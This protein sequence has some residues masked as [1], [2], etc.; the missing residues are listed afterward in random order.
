M[1]Q[2]KIGN[3]R[4][5]DVTFSAQLKDGNKIEVNQQHED[6]ATFKRRGDGLADF[7]TLKQSFQKMNSELEGADRRI[8][9]LEDYFHKQSILANSTELVTNQS[10]QNYLD[11]LTAHINAQFQLKLDEQNVQ[12]NKILTSFKSEIQG[13]LKEKANKAQVQRDQAYV[14]E[15]AVLIETKLDQILTG[16]YYESI[17]DKRLETKADQTDLESVQKNKADS[18]EVK[19]CVD[20]I[21]RLEILI[22]EGLYVDEEDE[23]EQ[24]IYGE[25]D[26]VDPEELKDQ[27]NNSD[28]N[29]SMMSITNIKPPPE[30]VKKIIRNTR[31]DNVLRGSSEFSRDDNQ[32]AAITVEENQDAP[33]SKSTDVGAK[34]QRENN[35]SVA[36]NQLQ[37]Q[38]GKKHQKNQNN[39]SSQGKI[40]IQNHGFLPAEEIKLET[41]LHAQSL[42]SPK[43]HSG[44]GSTHGNPDF[45]QLNTRNNTAVTPRDH[46]TR[47]KNS[48]KDSQKQIP[49]HIIE[50]IN[51]DPSPRHQAT[52]VSISI[53]GEQTITE[54]PHNMPSIG[55]KI[56]VGGKRKQ[57][58]T[59][60]NYD[61]QDL[62]VSHG[63]T[64]LRD[65]TPLNNLIND[66]M[67]NNSSM[68]RTSK[69]SSPRRRALQGIKRGQSSDQ[70]EKNLELENL[71]KELVIIN[72]RLKENSE[73]VMI[74]KSDINQNINKQIKILQTDIKLPQTFVNENHIKILK[75]LRQYDTMAQKI[76]EQETYDEKL[77]RKYLKQTINL[78]KDANHLKSVQEQE[79]E[80]TRVKLKTLETEFVVIKQN[81]E[82]VKKVLSST[83]QQT[84]AIGATN[85]S[86]QINVQ[87]PSI[88]ITQ[89]QNSYP[90]INLGGSTNRSQ[91]NYTPQLQTQSISTN[92][93]LVAMNT[94]QT[95]FEYFKSF[96][97]Q[98]IQGVYQKIEEEKQPLLDEVQNLKRENES[99]LREL[100]RFDALYRNM[101]NDYINILEENKS[102]IQKQSELEKQLATNKNYIKNATFQYF[103]QG[104]QMIHNTKLCSLLEGGLY[105]P[106][107][108]GYGDDTLGMQK[109]DSV[110]AKLV[111]TKRKLKQTFEQDMIEQLGATELNSKRKLGSPMHNL[112]QSISR[113][114]SNDFRARTSAI[115]EASSKQINKIDFSEL[116]ENQIKKNDPRTGHQSMRKRNT[117]NSS[118]LNNTLESHSTQNTRLKSIELYKRMIHNQ[119]NQTL[120]PSTALDVVS[121]I[122]NQNVLNDSFQQQSI[123]KTPM[124][125]T[126]PN[127]PLRAKFG[128]KDPFAQIRKNQASPQ[129]IG[130]KDNH[131]MQLKRFNYIQQQ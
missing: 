104:N 109:L 78:E 84:A 21:N 72:H 66:L 35:D 123:N 79:K 99:F 74:Y 23:E 60:S 19:D 102:Y 65:K 131:T 42:M 113:L 53:N 37:S 15:K 89:D 44:K 58:E 121:S 39:K 61:N 57:Q 98:K 87:D 120:S 110:T 47:K 22:H 77:K 75:L 69:W 116:P 62:N 80:Y 93:N 12:L 126:T 55:V 11:T 117:I 90:N 94:I 49:D 112:S 64:T 8:K 54:E 82:Y 127:S 5:P 17:L 129:L 31:N 28:H 105:D 95:D 86:L 2:T 33:Q 108:F 38:K 88:F 51:R 63:H 118:Q 85:N 124:S 67:S 43:N 101:L 46:S 130:E 76:N 7:L 13:F 10:L 36:R 114:G 48:K 107:K 29:Q 24:T 59:N 68:K 97:L 125:L 34:L 100:D 32:G 115:V 81:Q 71:K 83:K 25:D 26:E 103:G 41:S 30:H 27:V 92:L 45:A 1:E 14:L 119:F 40:P 96:V 9:S 6:K 50:I 16:K 20:K 18:V 56:S 70:N 111:D 73:N 128:T 106:K 3:P 122:Q 91:I 52:A 4:K